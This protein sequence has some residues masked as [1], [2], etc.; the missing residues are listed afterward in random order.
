VRFKLIFN[1]GDFINQALGN[2]STT[3][4]ER[5]LITFIVL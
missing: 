5:V 3:G 1:Q 2:L 4:M